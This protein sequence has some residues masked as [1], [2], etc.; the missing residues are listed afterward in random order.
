[1]DEK[2]SQIENLEQ[3]IYSAKEYSE[4]L[5][6]L[7]DLR[8]ASE[9]LQTNVERLHNENWSNVTPDIESSS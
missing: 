2:I 3:Q 8:S 7:D 9:V 4:E 5:N 6:Q 1:M